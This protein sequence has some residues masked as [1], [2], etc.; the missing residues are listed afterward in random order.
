VSSGPY[1]LIACCL[2]DSDAAAAA[3]AESA[4]LVQGLGARLAVVH[5]AQTPEQFTGGR[6]AYMPD[7]AELAAGLRADGLQMVQQRVATLP[8][9][10][11]PEPVVLQGDDPAAE[12]VA[13]AEREGCDL[14]VTAAHRRGLVRAL[15]GSFTASLVKDA[16][17]AVLV[18]RSR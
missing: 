7:P 9:S 5:V 11:Q 2:D 14:L 1:R 4:Q 3:L 16:P 13:W 12:V 15:L 6:T 18:S 17:C 10:A 8:D